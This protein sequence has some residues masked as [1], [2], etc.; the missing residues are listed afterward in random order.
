MSD[1]LDCTAC[2]ACCIGLTVRLSVADEARFTA[3][4]LLALSEID[5]QGLVR[6]LKQLPGG[7][8]I[9][10][11]REGGRF[12]CSVYEKRPGACREFESGARRC[13]LLRDERG[14]V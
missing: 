11:R 2:G 14:V 9:A 3:D 8:C 13:R 1:E 10:L 7:E 12:H 4:E 6:T 5:F